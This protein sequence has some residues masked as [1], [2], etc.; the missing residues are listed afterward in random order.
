MAI[1]GIATIKIVPS[2]TVH[3]V[4]IPKKASIYRCASMSARIRGMAALQDAISTDAGVVTLATLA[5]SIAR[6]LVDVFGPLHVPTCKVEGDAE[7]PAH[8]GSSLAVVL[9]ELVMNAVRHSE[10]RSVRVA[11]GGNDRVEHVRRGGLH[12]RARLRL[13]GGIGAGARLLALGSPVDG[14][15]TGTAGL[16]HPDVDL[17]GCQL[18]RPA[19]DPRHAGSGPGAS[20]RRTEI[21]QP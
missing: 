3:A 6:N 14:L 12:E 13:G 5:R 1:A 19:V 2:E 15:R 18:G 20:P 10:A 21:V 11:I 9:N 17:T 8:V 7:V 16:G 4:L